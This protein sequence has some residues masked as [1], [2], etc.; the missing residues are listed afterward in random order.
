[1]TG[2]LALIGPDTPRLTPEAS[3]PI[4]HSRHCSF[5]TASGRVGGT[6]TMAETHGVSVVA[7]ASLYYRQ[8]LLRRLGGESGRGPEPTDAALIAAAWLRWNE[9][10][11]ERLEGDWSFA[12]HDRRTSRFVCARD[13]YG[14]RTLFWS[15]FGST[16]AASSDPSLLLALDPNHFKLSRQGVIRTLC[17]WHGQGAWTVWE[18]LHEL[19]AGYRLTGRDGTEPK[20]ARFWTI[21]RDVA[22]AALTEKEA[23]EHLRTLLTAACRERL[24]RNARTSVTMSGGWDSTAIYG[25]LR[26]SL[27]RTGERAEHLQVISLKY[28]EGD[29]GN[30]DRYVN[31][32]LRFWD[33]TAVWP[34]TG[35]IPVAGPGFDSAALGPLPRL[36]HF[37]GINRAMARAAAAS[38]CSVL[39]SGAAGDLLFDIS[40]RFMA[41]LFRRFQW[42]QLRRE[43]K[44]RHLSGWNAFKEFCLRPS[45]PDRVLDLKADL[46]GRR[47]I[48]HP[49]SLLRAPWVPEPVWED[50]ELLA[51]ERTTAGEQRE[52]TRSFVGSTVTDHLRVLGL[53]HPVLHRVTSDLRRDAIQEEVDFRQ[54][55]LD[56]RLVAFSLSRPW[57][58]MARDGETKILL[59]RSMRDLLPAE[60]LAPRTSRTG[61]TS[62]YFIRSFHSELRDLIHRRPRPSPLVEMG[63]IDPE[64][65][66]ARLDEMLLTGSGPAGWIYRTLF[67][68]RWLGNC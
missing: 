46:M 22:A 54:P 48:V 53:I 33:D 15:N 50:A 58:D 16:F 7:D 51:E 27:A 60:V 26:G 39:L 18:K 55:F 37:H 14:S 49:L 25:A 28:P 12:L 65:F 44:A 3:T 59:R 43:W 56:D 9:G 40:E 38:G 4:L 68:E 13:P 61:T 6:V 47:R 30:E 41:D 21:K 35:E 20:V 2:Y 10:C 31:Q 24:S 42:L 62:A 63:V 64:P 66:E 29:P 34:D 57:S 36:H 11:L 23:A 52:F 1:M 32:V 17:L 45:V 19:P 5:F 67:L 8:D